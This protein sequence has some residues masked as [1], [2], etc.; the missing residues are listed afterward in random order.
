MRCATG[1]KALLLAQVGRGLA[2]VLDFFGKLRS[3]VG[4]SCLS[5]WPQ[6]DSG[7]HIG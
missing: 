2:L 3:A 1:V 7:V 6:A 4:F 5:Q